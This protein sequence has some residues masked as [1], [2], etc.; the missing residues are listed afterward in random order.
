MRQPNRSIPGISRPVE[1]LAPHVYSRAALDVNSTLPLFISLNNLQPMI[2]NVP[3]LRQIMAEDGGLEALVRIASTVRRAKDPAEANVRSLALRCLSQFGTCGPENV[4]VR[5]IEAQIVPVLVSTLECFWRAMEPEVRT[6]IEHELQP[7]AVVAARPPVNT[8]PSQPAE[9]NQP[10]Q[11]RTRRRAATIGAIVNHVERLTQP[12]QRPRGGLQ[13]RIPPHPSPLRIHTVARDNVENDDHTTDNTDINDENEFPVE[14]DR[15]RMD[16]DV[17]T[18]DETEDDGGMEDLITD[19]EGLRSPPPEGDVPYPTAFAASETQDPSSLTLPDTPPAN[20]VTPMDI[21]Q[22]SS[23]TDL[24]VSSPVPSLQTTN[25]I[26]VA[27]LLPT[28]RAPVPPNAPLVPFAVPPTQP[29]DVAANVIP[30][31]RLPPYSPPGMSHNYFLNGTRSW[32]IPRSE[33]ILECLKALAY[34]TKYPRLRASFTSTSFVP[35]VLQRYATPEDAK[36]EVNAF[37]IIERF[38]LRRHHPGD[39]PL[40]ANLVMRHYMRKD[41]VT[42]RQC[43]NLKCHQLEPEDQ[44][45]PILCRNCRFVSPFP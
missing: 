11:A 44:R 24:T 36:K 9:P 20:M 5:A 27:P 8:P 21:D 37:E 22:P 39:I 23:E 38:T 3:Q 18:T 31:T 6:A 17:V 16:I 43:S 28:D 35:T 40:W 15:D 26:P 19:A 12:I 41:D 45:F 32:W 30:Q 33:I 34:L 10:P 4:R 2:A 29:N 13:I 7:P 42:R 25:N 1:V 14:Q